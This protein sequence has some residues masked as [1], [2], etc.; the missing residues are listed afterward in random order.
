MSAARICSAFGSTMLKMNK[1]SVMCS[2]ARSIRT[3]KVTE[4]AAAPKLQTHYLPDTDGEDRARLSE[5]FDK[6]NRDIE[7]KRGRARLFAICHMY[8]QQHTFTEGDYIM[9]RKHFP[10]AIGTRI[11]LEK[12]MLVGGENVTLIGRPILDRDLV[13]IEATLVEKTM[14]QTN[15]NLVLIPKRGGY[16]RWHMT[17]KALSVLRI[18]EIKICHPLNESQS[19]V[20]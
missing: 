5:F 4:Q 3:V 15:T 20:Q 1:I 14:S 10:A 13:H 6:V 18:N 16:R 11:K 8:G 7:E 2:A 19:E 17:R 12:C 9:V